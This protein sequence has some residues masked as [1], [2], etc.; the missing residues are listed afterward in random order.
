V[1]AVDFR[2]YHKSSL[3]LIR[4]Y[5]LWESHITP[6][7]LGVACATNVSTEFHSLLTLTIKFI[8]SMIIISFSHPNAVLAR[9]VKKLKFFALQY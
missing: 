6:A 3:F 8:A 9:K 7:A 5:M 2:I 1:N 4:S